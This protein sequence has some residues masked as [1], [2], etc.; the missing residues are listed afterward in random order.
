M[1]RLQIEL[2]KDTV[3]ERAELDMQL[4][5]VRW[6]L[7]IAGKAVVFRLFASATEN[8]IVATLEGISGWEPKVDLQAITEVQP[9]RIQKIIDNSWRQ[10]ASAKEIQPDLIQ[11]LGYPKPIHGSQGGV[12]WCIQPI[13]ESGNLAAVWQINRE[14]DRWHLLLTIPSQNEPDA[15]ISARGTLEA[16]HK[17]GVFR[18]RERHRN[19]WQERWARSKVH[20]PEEKLQ[21]LWINGIYKLASSSYL[22]APANLQGLWPPDGQLAPWRGDY[23]C[24][25][26][27]QLTYWPAYSS[28]QLDLAEPLN[29]WLTEKVAPQASSLTKR[30]F[31]VDG[32]WMGTAYDVEGRLLGGRNNWMT[33]QYW[34]GGGGWM[35]QHLWWYYRYSQD[36]AFLRSRGYPFLKGCM[37]F[38][39]NILEKGED[40]W[41]HVPLSSSPEYFSNDEEAWTKDPTCDL[42]LIRNLANYCIIA[43]EAL[44]ID[45]PERVRW[46]GLVAKLAPYPIGNSGLKVQPNSEYDRSHRHPMHLFPIYPGG[47][48]TIE[49]SEEDRKLIDLSLRNWVYRGLG[50]WAGH[51]FPNSIPIAAR[52][53]RGNHAWNLLEIFAKAFV[54]PNGFH[55]NGDYQEL[56]ITAPYTTIIYT[57]ESECGITHAVN[58][59]LL[60]SWGGRLRIFPAVPDS[61]PDVSF[62]NLRAEGAFLVSA[63][64]RK[65]KVT[66]LSIL[67]EKGGQI[68][69]VKPLGPFPRGK[70]FEDQL[71]TF[72]TGERKE[73][74][75]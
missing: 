36:E 13:P 7:R 10:M 29:R 52:L 69:L 27:V 58:E 8:V 56:G 44:G 57:M 72:K 24:D 3:V 19:W 59:M 20:L 28:N 48:L 43:A 33:V 45:E 23:H 30:F 38:Y 65:G 31:G 75:D 15:V 63:E 49:G 6:D 32:L 68:R 37:Q 70:E 62:E 17:I 67:S 50:E 34:L 39:E 74:T 42:S 60:Q 71:L 9:V 18:L 41:L 25:M 40:G 35:A 11:E 21:R 16:A 26:N 64:R 14:Q 66:R 55:T 73:F 46:K 4:A 47:D 2:P 61:W 5:E 1:G 12:F 53:R 51:S 22:S 54:L